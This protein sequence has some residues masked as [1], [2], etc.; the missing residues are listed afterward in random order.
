[1][2]QAERDIN[3]K[4]KVLNYAKEKGNVAKT[5]RYFGISRAI[6]YLWKKSYDIHGEGSPI[7]NKPFLYVEE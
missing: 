6:F 4:L 1:M 7:N 3:R 5:C 2:T